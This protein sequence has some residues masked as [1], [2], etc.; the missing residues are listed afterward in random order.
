[1]E[2]LSQK[3]IHFIAKNVAEDSQAREE[4]VQRAGRMSWPTIIINGEVITGFD[5]GR[6]VS[7]LALS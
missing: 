4:L 7:L 5:R 2:L 6:L 3:D 1:M